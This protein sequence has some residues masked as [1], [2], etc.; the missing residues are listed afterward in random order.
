M[1]NVLRTNASLKGKRREEKVREGKIN[2]IV[3]TTKFKQRSR[4]NEVPASFG[5]FFNPTASTLFLVNA[6]KCPITLANRLQRLY[7]KERIV[8]RLR[9]MNGKF[10]YF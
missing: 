2:S 1:K 6:L 10:N 4:N 9:E 7:G 5:V 8:K 3:Q